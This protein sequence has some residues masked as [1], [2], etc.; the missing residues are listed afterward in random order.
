MPG[1]SDCGWCS[2]AGCA[3]IWGFNDLTPGRSDA[4]SGSGRERI[5]AAPGTTRPP[6]TPRPGRRLRSGRRRRRRARRRPV[7]GRRVATGDDGS[8]R[9]DDRRSSTA[10]RA[11]LRTLRHGSQHRRVSA[12]SPT[13]TACEYARLRRGLGRLRQVGRQHRRLRD[14]AR[15]PT[16]LRRLRQRVRH[17]QQPGRELRRRDDLHLYGAASPASPTATRRR[18][19]RTAAR[20]RSPM[21]RR[22]DVLRDR[23]ATRRTAT[24]PPA[25]RP[26]PARDL[27]VHEVR[28]RASPTATRPRRTRTAARRRSRRATNC[29]A[30]GRACDTQDSN[31][32]GCSRRQ[33]HVHRLRR[34]LGRLRHV[35][36]AN[37]NGCESSLTSTA[38][39]RRL[40]DTPATRRR[41]PRAATARRARTS[42]TRAAPTATP[43]P[44]PTPTAASAR[45]R[46]AAAGSARRR[47]R[48][49]SARASTTATRTARTTGDQAQERVRG[50]RGASGQCLEQ[51]DV[52]RLAST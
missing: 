22:A 41:A 44:R 4:R 45:R 6:T 31:G 9:S 3:D 23:R 27:H 16:K 51:L 34:G 20:R 26:T 19:T 17:G 15:P 39:V 12:T 24:A 13:A 11:G 48:T 25:T 1:S 37:T 10:G 43:G 18:R 35:E 14:V 36:R 50:V 38:I 47:T 33:L 46:R 5:R 8:M 49:A 30:C 28:P 32:A 2:A 40:Q 42:A 29:G 21:R 7:R 52:L